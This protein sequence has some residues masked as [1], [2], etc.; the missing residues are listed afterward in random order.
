MSNPSRHGMRPG[1]FGGTEAHANDAWRIE[2][3]YE[4][5]VPVPDAR[6][7][8]L[9]AEFLAEVKKLVMDAVKAVED[10]VK[11][12]NLAHCRAEKS[13]S[14]SSFPAYREN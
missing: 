14:T 8:R 9:V 5:G 1:R 3:I 7:D 2:S 13:H 6:G 4:R 12:S 11:A 10:E